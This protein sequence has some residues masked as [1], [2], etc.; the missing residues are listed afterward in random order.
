MDMESFI[1]ALDEYCQSPTLEDKSR[2]LVNIEVEEFASDQ[3]KIKKY[4]EKKA[5]IPKGYVAVNEK[6]MVTI[7]L[8]DLT[9]KYM[10]TSIKT[11]DLPDK[12]KAEIIAS[13]KFGDEEEL[14][15]FLES[16]SS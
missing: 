7:Y 5:E 6:N 9:T 11:T 14:F 8:G 1:G 16:Y 3:V 4:Y 12:I 2:G 15:R 13:K 10:D